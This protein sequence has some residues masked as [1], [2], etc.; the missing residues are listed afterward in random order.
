MTLNGGVRWDYLDRPGAGG[1]PEGE[2]FVAR[3]LSEVD[4][5]PQW[6]DW[7]VRTGAAYDLFGN[8]RTAIKGRRQVPGGGGPGRGGAK[9]PGD[10]DREEPTRT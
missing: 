4:H 5:V 3:R 2:H 10:A 1:K 7:S 9:Q 8:G 6:H